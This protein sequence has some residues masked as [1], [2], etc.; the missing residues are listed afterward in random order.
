MKHYSGLSEC[1]K[2]GSPVAFM[3]SRWIVTGCTEDTDSAG[4]ARFELTEMEP[5]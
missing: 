2:S 5:R 4:A 1:M 3:G